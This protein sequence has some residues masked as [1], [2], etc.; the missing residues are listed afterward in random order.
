MEPISYIIPGVR[1]NPVTQESDLWVLKVKKDVTV[2]WQKTYGLPGKWDEALGAAPASASGVIVAAYYENPDANMDWYAA[3]INIEGDGTLQWARQF[4]N[5]S[6]DWTNLLIATSEGG[7]MGI[8]VTLTDDMDSQIF[9]LRMDANGN[10]SSSCGCFSSL[11]LNS[12]DTTTTAMSTSNSVVNTNATVTETTTQR[13]L[14][15]VVGC[16]VM[17]VQ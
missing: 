2:A 17:C 3:V 11:S 13:K 15:S 9:A 1:T 14:V 5:G 6:L 10:I 4:K 16:S 12:V 8:G 7:F